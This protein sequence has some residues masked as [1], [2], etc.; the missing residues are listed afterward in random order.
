MDEGKRGIGA[1]GA[2]VAV[3]VGGRE[4]GEVDEGG[5]SEAHDAGGGVVVDVEADGAEGA[6]LVAEQAGGAE[7]RKNA[8]VRDVVDEDGTR[9]A[10]LAFP[11]RHQ[12]GF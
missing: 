5:A 4:A 12:R 1:V 7:V 10:I 9:P 2:E 3:R 11:N 6:A 8:V